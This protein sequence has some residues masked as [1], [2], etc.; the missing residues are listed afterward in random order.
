[1]L[2]VGVQLLGVGATIAWRAAVK[3]AVR[4]FARDATAHGYPVRSS[5]P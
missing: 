2:I 1:M 5:L 3:S 4:R